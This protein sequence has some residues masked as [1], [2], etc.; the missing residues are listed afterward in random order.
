MLPPWPAIS[1]GP[2]LTEGPPGWR[3]RQTSPA[4][5][6]LNPSMLLSPGSPSPASNLQSEHHLYQPHASLAGFKH[7]SEREVGAQRGAQCLPQGGLPAGGSP[8]PSDSCGTAL[9]I[10]PCTLICSILNGLQFP[11][12]GR[13]RREEG[14]AAEGMWSKSGALGPVGNLEARWRSC[15]EFSQ[16]GIKGLGQRRWGG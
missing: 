13:E 6:H 16:T 14:G 8:P 2:Q 11:S 4:E 5:P 12:W 1:L 10:S 3:W 9:G 7:G 15:V